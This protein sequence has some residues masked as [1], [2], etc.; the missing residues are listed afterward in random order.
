M[1]RVSPPLNSV[2]GRKVKNMN[3]KLALASAFALVAFVPGM[4]A[5][6]AATNI[7]SAVD[8]NLSS[9]VPLIL[10]LTFLGIGLGVLFGALHKI[11]HG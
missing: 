6:D 9:W 1:V 7:S 10:T 2:G 8:S 11:Q 5:A 4:A 3:M